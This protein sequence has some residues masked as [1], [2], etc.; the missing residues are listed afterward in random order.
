MILKLDEIIKSLNLTNLLS[1]FISDKK[2]IGDG[3]NQISGGQAQRISI[4]RALYRN[5]E[6]LVMDEPTSNL[7]N[8]NEKKIMDLIFFNL[9]KTKTIIFT[10]HNS[11]NLKICR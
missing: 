4:A 7:D 9:F 5:S 8:E 3:A 11:D 1:L 10:S 2:T 6:I